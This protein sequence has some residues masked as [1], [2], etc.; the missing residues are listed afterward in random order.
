M[1]Y[2]VL[3]ERVYAIN[4][5]VDYYKLQVLPSD[6]LS[7]YMHSIG[8]KPLVAKENDFQIKHNGRKLAFCQ[9]FS[10]FL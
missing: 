2:S 6:W 3:I 10:S 1:T 5:L 8:N 9:G 4:Q 7:Y